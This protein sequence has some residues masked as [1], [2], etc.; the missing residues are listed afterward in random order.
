[1]PLYRVEVTQV[2]RGWVEVKSPHPLL[3]QQDARGV[4]ADQAQDPGDFSWETTKVSAGEV[5]EIDEGLKA[6][7]E[8]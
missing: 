5:W 6:Q 1:M 3:A 4:V 8:E 2:R 7:V